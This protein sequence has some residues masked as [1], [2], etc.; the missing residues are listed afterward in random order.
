MLD[1]IEETLY[2]LLKQVKKEGSLHYPF[3][4]TDEDTYRLR[5]DSN[6]RESHKIIKD[7]QLIQY[8]NGTKIGSEDDVNYSD[9][10]YLADGVELTDDG[11]SKLGYLSE[12][13]GR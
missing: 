12:K 5:N 7:E 3:D 2:H 10:P 13:F 1:D 11:E 9:S 4:S 6:F 8:F